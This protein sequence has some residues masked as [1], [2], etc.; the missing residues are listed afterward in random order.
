M[1]D[2]EQVIVVLAEVVIKLAERNEA[3]DKR[4]EAQRES[5]ELGVWLLNHP[6]LIKKKPS[7]CVIE[8]DLA[9]GTAP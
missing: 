2:A 7:E 4:C 9:S 3:L 1:P 6:D 8:A 5:A